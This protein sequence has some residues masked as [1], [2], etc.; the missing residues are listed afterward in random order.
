MM[1]HVIFGNV[2]LL[3][4]II[5]YTVI[6]SSDPQIYFHAFYSFIEKIERHA[7][8]CDIIV[9]YILPIMQEKT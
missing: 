6:H 5:N 8:L 2:I 4:F 7:C 9:A 1:C 3:F